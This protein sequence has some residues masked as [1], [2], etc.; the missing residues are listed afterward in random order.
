MLKEDIQ[1]RLD[2]PC[3]PEGSLGFVE[4]ITA[5]MATFKDASVTT[6]AQQ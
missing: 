5:N 6:G 4:D 3:K 1:N 2:G